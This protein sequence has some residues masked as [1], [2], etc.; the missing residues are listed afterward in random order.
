MP[1][2]SQFLS[3]HTPPIAIR[4]RAEHA[5]SVAIPLSARIG[6]HITNRDSYQTWHCANTIRSRRQLANYHSH[7][8]T[9]RPLR[10]LS[11][12]ASLIAI[13][14]RIGIAQTRFV[15][16][17]AFMRA[18]KA[19]D[20]CAFRRCFGSPSPRLFAAKG[21]SPARGLEKVLRPEC[22]EGLECVR[23]ERLS[24]PTPKPFPGRAQRCR[25]HR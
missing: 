24:D 21:I 1:A 11:A 3:G 19:I 15:S 8:S 4:T 22:A 10:F 7:Q 6:A 23:G 2:Q 14:T 13:R 5:S 16:G 25:E 17:H 9:P 12:H 20:G 18:V